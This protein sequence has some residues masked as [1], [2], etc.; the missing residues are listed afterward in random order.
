MVTQ[1]HGRICFT[2]LKGGQ[3]N[4]GIVTR[5]QL[6]AFPAKKIW[7]GRIVYAPAAATGLLTA[8]TN[9]ETAETLDPYIAGWATV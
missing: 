2:A 6:K 3:N 4:F 1:R 5:F 9:F 8:F 7:D